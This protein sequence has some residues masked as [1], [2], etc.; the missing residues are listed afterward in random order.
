MRQLTNNLYAYIEFRHWTVK[1][2]GA[3]KISAVAFFPGYLFPGSFFP[4]YLF[5]GYFF[6]RLHFFRVSFLRVSFFPKKKAYTPFSGH[7][8][9]Q[10]PNKTDPSNLQAFQCKITI[11]PFY[12][13]VVLY[14]SVLIIYSIKTKFNFINKHQIN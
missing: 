8:F 10:A 4:G 11:E 9:F 12:Y 3:K 1:M 5:P 14:L 2:E 13:F 6:S 7:P